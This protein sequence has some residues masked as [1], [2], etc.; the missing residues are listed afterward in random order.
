MIH[1]RIYLRKVNKRV[2]SPALMLSKK[3]LSLSV[4][5]E[6]HVFTGCPFPSLYAGPLNQD[7]FVVDNP[8][9]ISSALL[10]DLANLVKKVQSGMF[11]DMKEIFS[12][13]VA[14]LQR[15][16]LVR[17]HTILVCKDPG[18]A[19]YSDMGLLLPRIIISPYHHK[20]C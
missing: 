3:G 12:D 18:Y 1:R 7:Q 5:P 15:L 8:M 2:H 19:R 4:S 6:Y 10:S 17:Y 11:V 20:I 9:V 16:P 13:S 14:L